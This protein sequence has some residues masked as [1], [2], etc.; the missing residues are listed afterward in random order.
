MMVRSL[1]ILRMMQI[2]TSGNMEAGGEIPRPCNM[3]SRKR[4]A[5]ARAV[6]ASVAHN[7]FTAM[8][9]PKFRGKNFRWEH[10]E[11]MAAGMTVGLGLTGPYPESVE[12]EMQGIAAVSAR[13]TVQ[14]CLKESNVQEW[15][16]LEE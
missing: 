1:A 15:M 13:Y 16:P 2:A 12:K 11:D 14:F 5:I 3:L 6:G 9:N 7:M 8:L 10:L 4:E